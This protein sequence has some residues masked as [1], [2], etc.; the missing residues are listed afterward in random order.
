MIIAILTML[1]RSSECAETLDVLRAPRGHDLKVG[2]SLI[3]TIMKLKAD[4]PK[5]H[6]SLHVSW[7]DSLVNTSYM[8]MAV[9]TLLTPIGNIARYLVG[10]KHLTISEMRHLFFET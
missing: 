2:R 6:E 7:Y 1:R 8:R 3:D 4:F 5:I 10:V 9:F